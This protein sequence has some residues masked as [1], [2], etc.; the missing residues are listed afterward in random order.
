MDADRVSLGVGG[1]KLERSVVGAEG[2][3]V[4]GFEDGFAVHESHG[5]SL[6]ESDADGVVAARDGV[7]VAAEGGVH[8][9]QTL[10]ALLRPR[11]KFSRVVQCSSTVR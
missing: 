6:F 8:R 11:V 3:D 1:E 2:E 7:D 9:A 4:R 10:G 5:L